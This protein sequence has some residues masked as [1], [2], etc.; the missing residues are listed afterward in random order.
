MKQKTNRINSLREMLFL[1]LLV[2]NNFI[3]FYFLSIAFIN[4]I[5]PF[6]KHSALDF[7]LRFALYGFIVS[8]FFSLISL[9]LAYLFKKYFI[10]V[11]TGQLKLFL[12]QVSFLF[13]IF[14]A[15]FFAVFFLHILKP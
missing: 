5:G 6:R 13:L 12:I 10:P 4:P 2:A 8:L 14:A 1:V 9:S 7:Y 3:A 11:L 15:A